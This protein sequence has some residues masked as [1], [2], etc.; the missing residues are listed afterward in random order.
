MCDRKIVQSIIYNN[1]IYIPHKRIYKEEKTNIKQKG[2]KK[3]SPSRFL[4]FIPSMERKS[5]TVYLTHVFCPSCFQ[6]LLLS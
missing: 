1:S 6:L 3:F 4:L 2:E 5:C